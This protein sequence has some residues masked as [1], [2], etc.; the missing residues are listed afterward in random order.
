M[1]IISPLCKKRLMGDIRI[2]R[3]DPHQYIDVSPDDKDILVWYFMVKGPDFSDFNGGYYIGKIMYN[4][5]YPFKPPDFMMLTPSGRF[6][7]GTKICLSNSSY[8][9][10]EWSPMWTIHATLTGFLSIMLDDK[11]HGISHIHSSKQERN[12]FATNA[13]D[14]NKKNHKDIL[15]LFSRFVDEDGNPIT[16]DK[17]EIPETP[18]THETP[19]THETPKTPETL[20][21]KKNIEE[22]VKTK[23]VNDETLTVKTDTKNELVND[24]TLEIKPVKKT[25]KKIVKKAAKTELVDDETLEVKKVVKKVTKTELVDDKTLEV[26]QVKQVKQ[27]KKIVKK[28][29]KTELVDDETLEVKPVK[30]IVKKVVKRIINDDE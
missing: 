11:E 21:V 2:L 25:I 3:R 18:K 6:N 24:E 26:K 1:N 4:T 17:N 9:Q 19:E 7:I 27:V 30:K 20:Q 28:A 23:L 15:K 22:I 14:Y 16:K 8:H 10:N 29:T 12:Q 5:E 13:V